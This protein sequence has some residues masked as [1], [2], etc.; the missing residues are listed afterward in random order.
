MTPNDGLTE[1]AIK[2]SATGPDSASRISG[3]RRRLLRAMAISCG[4]FLPGIVR[5]A[6]GVAQPWERWVVL[7]AVAFVVA[8]TTWSW[9]TLPTRLAV[10]VDEEHIQRTSAAAHPCVKCGAALIPLDG[11][12]C[13][14]CGATQPLGRA[15]AVILA[16]LG[17]VLVALLLR[18]WL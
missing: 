14:R 8:G 18:L 4:A 16:V 17:V 2:L 13:W 10:A 6:A 1:E 9:V 3:A 12:R 7:S 11:G 15:G 5:T